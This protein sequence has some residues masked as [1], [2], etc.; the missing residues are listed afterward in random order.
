MITLCSLR[1]ELDRPQGEALLVGLI[2]SVAMLQEPTWQGIVGGF[3][4][5]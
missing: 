1:L 3:W 5:L 2:K 4:G